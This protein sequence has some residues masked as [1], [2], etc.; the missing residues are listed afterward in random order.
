MKHGKIL[1]EAKV[2]INGER[3][4]QYGNPE[5]SFRMIDAFWSFYLGQ[6]ISAQQVAEMMILLKLARQKT[7]EGKRDNF[8]DM[9]GYAAL[10]ADMAGCGL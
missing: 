5:D 4:D 3:R 8:V 6:S 2:I 1:D 7:G 10:A 9:C